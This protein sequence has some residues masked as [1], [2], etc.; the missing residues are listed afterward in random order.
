M[1]DDNRPPQPK[2]DGFHE[3]ELVNLRTDSTVTFDC[4]IFLPANK[5]LIHWLRAGTVFGPIHAEKL[6]KLGSPSVLVP[7]AQMAAYLTYVGKS[8]GEPTPIGKDL[9][10]IKGT[11]PEKETI[12]VFGGSFQSDN[13]I[14]VIKGDKAATEAPVAP[15]KPKMQVDVDFINVSIAAIQKVFSSICNVE[16]KFQTPTKRTEKSVA[17]FPINIASFIDLNS[18]SIRGTIGL[19]FPTLTYLNLL[20]AATGLKFANLNE[21]VTLGAGEFMSHIFATARPGLASIGYNVDLAVPFL[22][23]GEEISVR[24][25]LPS[26]GFSFLISSD[27]GQFQ[28]EVGIKTGS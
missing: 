18:G 11:R 1:S 28:Y 13:G 24:H 16:L 6:V 2:L 21:A 8:Q 22:V 20:F 27:V 23:S 3:I 10:H 5:K 12:R 17:P 4:H 9:I 15:P 7:E 25:V 26:A 19:C 14:T